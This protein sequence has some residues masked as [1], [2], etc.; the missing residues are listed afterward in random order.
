VVVRVTSAVALPVAME[1]GD[2][3][4]VDERTGA[5]RLVR[6]VPLTAEQVAHLVAV[7]AATVERPPRSRA[8]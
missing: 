3:L 7:G 8:G 2:A 6:A 5:V 4:V 1:A